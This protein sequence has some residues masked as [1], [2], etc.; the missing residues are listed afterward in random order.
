MVSSGAALAQVSIAFSEMLSHVVRAE[1]IVH[2]GS[3]L[4]VGCLQGWEVL[5]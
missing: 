3:D 1:V 4:G 5:G 2:S